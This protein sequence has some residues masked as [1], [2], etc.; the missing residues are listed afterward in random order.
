MEGDS[1][2]LVFLGGQIS[3]GRGNREEFLAVGEV[4]VEFG[5][6][7]SEVAELK[8]L[9]LFGVDDDYSESYRVFHEFEFYSVASSVDVEEFALL[10]IFDDF[11]FEFFSELVETELGGELNFDFFFFSGIE[12]EVRFREDG[13]EHFFEFFQLFVEVEG[14]IDGLFGVVDK[15]D[16]VRDLFV[17]A[18]DAEVD[19]G[20]FRFFQFE[21]EGRS[22][23]EDSH[24]DFVQIVDVEGD[25]FVVAGAFSWGE[26][27]RDF[28]DVVFHLLDEAALVFD[29]FDLQGHDYLSGGETDVEV[30]L[31]FEISFDAHG[32]G[33]AV[34]YLEGGD[35]GKGLAQDKAGAEVVGEE[36][37][38]DAWFSCGA[39]E[40]ELV[41]G[42]GGDL[43]GNEGLGFEEGVVGEGDEF[44][45]DLEAFVLFDGAVFRENLYEGDALRFLD[46]EV[47]VELSLVEDFNDFAA[48]FV[49]VDVSELQCVG[50][51]RVQRRRH[52]LEEHTVVQDVSDSLDVQRYGAA[53]SLQIA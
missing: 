13:D 33:V 38:V 16:L 47:E 32:A 12:T 9:G 44:D 25:G 52:S 49:H 48:L 29:V 42:S 10:L 8:L 6:D 41:G 23:S 37:E 27:D 28:Q 30:G 1:E 20:V 36:G 18:D 51:V 5:A 45:F 50:G 17:D 14:E 2:E 19:V 40:V 4:P 21:F 31:L 22:L 43:E 11:E 24:S 34:S 39:E 7:V 53:L 26:G 3:F 35:N 15:L 46:R